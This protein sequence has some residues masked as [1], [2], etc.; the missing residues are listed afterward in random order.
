MLEPGGGGVMLLG[1]SVF[2]EIN[3][4]KV[5]ALM[6]QETGDYGEPK[7]IPRGLILKY[8]PLEQNCAFHETWSWKEY[9]RMSILQEVKGCLLLLHGRINMWELQQ[10]Y[11]DI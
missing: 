10:E 11:W 7:F 6:L 4:K 2:R 3:R 9:Q 1:R 5:R 8:L